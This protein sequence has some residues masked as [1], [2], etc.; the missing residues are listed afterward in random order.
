[1]TRSQGYRFLT[2]F[3]LISVLVSAASLAWKTRIAGC[4]G[5]GYSPDNMMAS[6]SQ[7]SFGDY[8][9]GALILGME[10]QADSAIKKADVLAFGYSHIH[11]ALSGDATANF[12]NTSRYKFYNVSASGTNSTF[13]DAV[14]SRLKLD[15]TVV[16][17]NADPFFVS[18]QTSSRTP[19][20]KQLIDE[21]ARYDLVYR[22]KKLWQFIHRRAC[23]ASIL[24][25]CGGGFSFYRDISTGRLR[26][27]YAEL[28][29]P[30]MPRLP[31]VRRQSFDR[32]SAQAYKEYAHAFFARHKLN[33]SCAII[34]VVPSSFD[35]ERLGEYIAAAT[36]APYVN[37]S[38][39][40][41]TTVDKGHLDDE[42]LEKWSDAFWKA[43]QP[44]IDRCS[45]AK[46]S[47]R[48]S[49]NFKKRD[50]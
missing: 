10:P 46:N 25:L 18:D 11:R 48:Q 31:V 45:L 13:A 23:A 27:N 22:A 49:T 3:V 21:P 28:F 17:I 15:P 24:S 7:A 12:F 19:V 1:M 35:N 47:K 32:I 50:Q 34:T 9:Q 39:D 36:G 43:A 5:K 8:E 30:N 33:A 14:L 4:S 6:C 16:V 44:I 37:P 29:G 40:G 38:M 2:A 26:I 41:L 20:L 42:S